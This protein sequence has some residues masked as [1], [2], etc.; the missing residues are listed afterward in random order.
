MHKHTEFDVMCFT[1]GNILRGATDA[2]LGMFV[3]SQQW[4]SDSDAK[5]IFENAGYSLTKVE[6]DALWTAEYVWDTFTA[7]MP[8]HIRVPKFSEILETLGQAGN[9][10]TRQLLD[11]MKEAKNVYTSDVLDNCNGKCQPMSMALTLDLPHLCCCIFFCCVSGC[12]LRYWKTPRCQPAVA[13][14]NSLP[15]CEQHYGLSLI[16]ARRHMCQMCKLF[17][18]VVI[19]GTPLDDVHR[20]MIEQNLH[21][22]LFA[23]ERPM[24]I[25]IK[26]F[27]SNDVMQRINE[28]HTIVP[29]YVPRDAYEENVPVIPLGSVMYTDETD[30]QIVAW[31]NIRKLNKNGDWNPV[32]MDQY[33]TINRVF[34][35]SRTL[36]SMLEY[37]YPIDGRPPL[38]K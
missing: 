4:D 20:E 30:K 17:N 32:S 5:T 27:C 38:C 19:R 3:Q 18:V 16:N 31:V 15:Y 28:G 8:T 36:C 24:N 14:Q 6:E 33:N 12:I 9:Q 35:S 25:S 13:K 11:T 21:V 2:Q 37:G 26:R 34:L 1:Y 7:R 29:E 22:P 23:Y 10:T